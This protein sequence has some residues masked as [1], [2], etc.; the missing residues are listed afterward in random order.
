M[1]GPLPVPRLTPSDSARRRTKRACLNC[2]RK[3]LKCNGLQPCAT[4]VSRNSTCAYIPPPADMSR[5]RA[6]PTSSSPRQGTATNDANASSAA[7]IL[8]NLVPRPVEPTYQGRGQLN[9]DGNPKA[10]SRG[11]SEGERLNEQS[12]LLNDGKGRLLYLGDS[13]S[14]SF[15]DTIRRLVENTLGPSDFTTDP[16]RHKLVEGSITVA[17]KPTHVLPDR[18]AAEFLIDS[19][20]SNTIGILYVLDREACAREVAQIYENPLGV[21][22]SRLSILN[23]LFAVG[24]QMTRSSAA[25]SF[26]ESQI[27]KRLDAGPVDRAELFYLNATHL[28]DPISGF[29]DGDITSIQA[30]LLITVFMLTV[31]KRNAAWAFF[32]MAVRSAYALGLHRREADLGFAPAEQRIRRNIWKSL[33]VM[34]CFISAM[35]G[36][37]NGINSRDAPQ[38]SFAS[39]EDDAGGEKSIEA[40][41]LTASTRASQLISDI[42]SCVYA[43][44]KISVK[45][46]HNLSSRF[47]AWKACLPPILHWQNISLPNEDPRTTLAQLHVNLSYFHG[48]IL[49]TRPFLLQ[50]LISLTRA[51]KGDGGMIGQP[52]TDDRDETNSARAEVF[53]PACVRSAVYSIDA[54]QSA[55]LKRA[56]P[57]RDP[58]VIYWLFS[59]ALIVFSNGFATVCNDVDTARAMQTALNLHQYLGEVDPLARRY[60]QILVAFHAAISRKEMVAANDPPATTRGG[61]ENIFN[62]FFGGFGAAGGT[63]MPT[64]PLSAGPASLDHRRRSSNPASSTNASAIQAGADW[65]PYFP[66]SSL[67]SNSMASASVTTAGMM[68]SVT[69]ISPPDYC[70]DFDAFFNNTNTMTSTHTP[71]H[72]TIDDWFK[73]F[74]AVSDDGTAHESY[75]SFFTEDAKLMM[76]DKVAVGR[77]E[78]L[79]VRTEMW[80]AIVS[81]HHTF[82]YFTNPQLPNTV[83]LQGTVTYGFKNGKEGDMEWVAKAIFEGEGK[84]RRLGFYQ[85]FLN[86]GKR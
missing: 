62:A 77:Q 19:F 68:G 58:F 83:L 45:L 2:Q 70:L 21:D 25:H 11:S 79:N 30:L 41:A 80:T 10:T 17:K 24:L 86:A 71:Q 33:Y 59:A 53:P 51:S 60:N 37:P 14:L 81:R 50:K 3:K 38:S 6:R 13:A 16:H 73:A 35:L 5:A 55:L 44:R 39:D 32:G 67:R 1:T 72:E 20:F 4:C 8:A 42:L 84:S 66:S 48:I 29:E 23:L 64:H 36:R 82:E 40:D 34:D 7:S 43:E 76:G 49:L 22:Q 63:S 18:E 61:S 28:N 46:A 56:L 85:V 15:L 12:R 75:P 54:V 9:G 52:K 47:H 57:R 26:R 65:Q 69:G 78:I 27:L 31:A 74:Y